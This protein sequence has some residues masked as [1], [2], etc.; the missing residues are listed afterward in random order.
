MR[1]PNSAITSFPVPPTLALPKTQA[2][3]N[4]LPVFSL[5]RSKYSSSDSAALHQFAAREVDGGSAQLGDRELVALCR[6]HCKGG[7][8]ETVAKRGRPP[9]A[10]LGEDGGPAPPERGAVEHVVMDKTRHMDQLDRDA[11][12][13]RCPPA[14]GTGAEQYQHRTHSLAAGLES[15]NC[16]GSQ[17]AFALRCREQAFFDFGQAVREPGARTLEYSGYRLRG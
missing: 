13:N 15:R 5:Q 8:E 6:E 14:S 11:G 10:G 2:A 9:P 3:A 12:A 16:V 1:W 17:R 7:R 4:N